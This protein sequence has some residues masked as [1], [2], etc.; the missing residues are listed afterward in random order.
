MSKTFLIGLTGY[1][2]TGKDTVRDI[3]QGEGFAGFA[4][5]DPIRAMLRELLT[6]NGISE[7]YMDERALKES[8]IEQLGVSYRHMA[9]TLGTEWGRRLADDF[10]LRI[11]RAYLDDMQAQGETHFCESDVRFVNEAQWVREQGGVIWR[12]E[13]PQA[14]PVR[15]H[16]SEAEL[17]LFKADK[18]IDNSG[19]FDQLADQVHAALEEFV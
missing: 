8:P 1:A 11:A 2:G 14:L 16:V 17:Y 10:W 9:Q 12:I 4:F 15:T 19:S 18:T 3:L 5:A 6:S 13:R 7:C